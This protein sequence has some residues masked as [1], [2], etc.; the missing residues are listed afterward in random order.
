MTELCT[1]LLPRE[2][3]RYLMGV[4]MPIDL[5][6]GVRRGV[7][8]FDCVLPTRNARNGQVFTSRGK[9]SIRNAKFARDPSPRSASRNASCDR[10]PR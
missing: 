6:E 4:G 2:R 3:P 1:A 9:L 5:L 7:D 8:M 10:A